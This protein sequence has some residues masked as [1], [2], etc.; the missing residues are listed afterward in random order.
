M[1]LL[2]NPLCKS[3]T[4]V[5]AAVLATLASTSTNGLKLTIRGRRVGLDQP[6]VPRAPSY[7]RF[8]QTSPSVT[9]YVPCD[10]ATPI[11]LFFRLIEGYA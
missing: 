9:L 1:E 11:V 3:R 7:Q 2:V 6:A 5:G 8:V 4:A 10:L